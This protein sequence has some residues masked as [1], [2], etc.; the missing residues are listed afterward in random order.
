VIDDPVWLKLIWSSLNLRPE[1]R[2]TEVHF[3]PLVRLLWFHQAGY[4]CTAAGVVA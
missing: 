1:D 2:L 3:Y 4:A